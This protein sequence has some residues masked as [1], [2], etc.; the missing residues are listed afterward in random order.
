[1][2]NVASSDPAMSCVRTVES[3]NW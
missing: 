1:M 2:E 3:R